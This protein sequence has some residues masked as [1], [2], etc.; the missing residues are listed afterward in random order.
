MAETKD[1]RKKR[2]EIAQQLTR[3]INDAEVYHAIRR[4]A[5]DA[6]AGLARRVDRMS[7]AFREKHKLAGHVPLARFYVKGGN[8]FSAL[9]RSVSDGGPASSD[10]A[11]VPRS[12][13]GDSDWDTQVVVNPWLPQPLQAELYAEID[14]LVTDE[15]VAAAADFARAYLDAPGPRVLSAHVVGDYRLTPDE[16]PPKHTTLD[17][18]AGEPGSPLRLATPRLVRID[19]VKPFLLYRLGYFWRAELSP[20]A[21]GEKL[22]IRRPVLMELIDITLPRRDT[23]EAVGVWRDLEDAPG[24]PGAQLQIDVREVWGVELPLPDLF[25][26][27][28]EN[29]TMLCEITVDRSEHADKRPKRVARFDKIRLHCLAIGEESARRFVEVVNSI[30]GGPLADD[31]EQGTQQLLSTLDRWVA[32]RWRWMCAGFAGRQVDSATTRRVLAARER[33][34]ALFLRVSARSGLT[35][36]A[37]S[38]DLY[39]MESLAMNPFVE[40][41]RLP[42]SGVDMAVIVRIP[43]SG[44][45]ALDAVAGLMALVLQQIRTGTQRTSPSGSRDNTGRLVAGAA[46]VNR[47]EARMQPHSTTRQHDISY[48]WTHVV[49]ENDRPIMLITFTTASASDAPFRPASDPAQAGAAYCSLADVARQRKAAGALIED[50]VVRLAFAD[51][52]E[53]LTSLL[54]DL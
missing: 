19:G 50:Y 46:P 32:E 24:L 17:M 15:L 28:R 51:Q 45:E 8:A 47:L 12:A 48:E 6:L 38:D 22:Q 10:Q 3:E 40:A 14:R 30:A 34:K 49:F 41:S 31:A 26:H 11:L 2:R 27:L 16:R 20:D 23:I 4:I 52:L 1:E 29:L 33:M 54:P 9:M 13:G 43:Q 25:Y 7:A 42:F 5:L 39:L 36:A 35:S 37:F 53:A 44:S 21:R 18:P